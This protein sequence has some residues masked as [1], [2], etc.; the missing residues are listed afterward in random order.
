MKRV[1]L[2]ETNLCNL[3]NDQKDLF[4]VSIRIAYL[5]QDRTER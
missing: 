1:H 5:D 4:T 3:L 2:L